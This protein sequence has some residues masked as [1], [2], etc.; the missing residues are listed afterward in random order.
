M[1][2]NFLKFDEFRFSYEFIHHFLFK[3][4]TS[5][6]GEISHTPTLITYKVIFLRVPNK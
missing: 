4:L 5:I 6:L 2:I 1:I 3:I